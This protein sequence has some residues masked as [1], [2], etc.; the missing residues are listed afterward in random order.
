MEPS[1]AAKLR[2]LEAESNKLKKLLAEAHLDD[3]E[4][5]DI[6]VDFGVSGQ[7]VTWLLDQAAIFSGYPIAVRTAHLATCHQRCLGRNDR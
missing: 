4:C 7:Y 5:I 1:D 6:A 2:E 3:F